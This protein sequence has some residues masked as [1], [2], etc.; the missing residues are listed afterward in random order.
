[1]Y[2]DLDEEPD[3]HLGEAAYCKRCGSGGYINMCLELLDIH[4][5]QLKNS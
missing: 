4:L 5:N 3:F 1:M 2:Q